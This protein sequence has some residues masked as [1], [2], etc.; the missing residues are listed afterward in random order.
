VAD[1]AEKQKAKITTDLKKFCTRKELAALFAGTKLNRWILVVPIHDSAQ[2]NLYLTAKT[3][4]VGALALPYVADDFEALV[5]DL[6]CFEADSREAR[7]LRRRLITL[8]PQP[9]TPEQ[10]DRW[11][12]ASNPLVTALSEKLAKRLGSHEPGRH[13]QL[14]RPW[15]AG[16]VGG[17]AA[18]VGELLCSPIML[19][20]SSR[21]GPEKG[22]LGPLS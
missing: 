8:P 5:H 2:V 19:P 4:Q 10:I 7:A 15:Y 11:T 14:K 17:A 16:R 12:Q 9:P 3:A 18:R 21:A 13:C 6:D 22:A 1:R 20:R